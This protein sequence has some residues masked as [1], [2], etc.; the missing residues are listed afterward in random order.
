MN[1]KICLSNKFSSTKR[2]SRV[3]P[4]IEFNE[5]SKCESMLFLPETNQQIVTG[6]LITKGKL[7]L[8][9]SIC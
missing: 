8:F 3:L 4:A 2:L 9:K 7:I 6:Y 1:K 5:E